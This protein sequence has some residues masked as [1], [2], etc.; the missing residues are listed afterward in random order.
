M[1]QCRSYFDVA[2][3]ARD[4]SRQARERYRRDG[5]AIPSSPHVVR[6]V[7]AVAGADR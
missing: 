7:E 5:V 1:Y 6:C 2:S 3:V 4:G